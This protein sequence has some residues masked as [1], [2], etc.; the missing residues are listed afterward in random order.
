[1][2]VRPHKQFSN[3]TRDTTKEE[4]RGQGERVKKGVG[5]KTEW[6]ERTRKKR[7]G[8][9]ERKR[10]GKERGEEGV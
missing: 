7:L 5:E 10:R 2:C 8:K 9:G 1:M 3:Q 6:E 4:T